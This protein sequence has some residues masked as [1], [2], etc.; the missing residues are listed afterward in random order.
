M[1]KASWLF[2]DKLALKMFIVLEVVGSLLY[3]PYYGLVTN[4]VLERWALAL[5]GNV[6]YGIVWSFVMAKLT[7]WLARRW[8]VS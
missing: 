7:A 2:K 1:S 5:A 4:F 8:I 6:P 3:V